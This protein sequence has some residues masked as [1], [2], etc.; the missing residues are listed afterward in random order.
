MTHVVL[1]IRP[2][3]AGE[4]DPAG[5]V[6][7]VLAGHV[8]STEPGPVLHVDV[9]PVGAEESQALAE[10]VLGRQV[11]G[12]VPLQLVLMV[13]SCPSTQQQRHQAK[14][15]SASS[16]LQAASANLNIVMIRPF[17]SDTIVVSSD[18]DPTHS[19]NAA[20]CRAPRERLDS[21][22]HHPIIVTSY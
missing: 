1:D 2:A 22:V 13:H 10:P 16:N 12:R 14:V 4:K 18:S 8:E 6:V 11:E 5:L 21:Q 3:A 15:A 7:A 19:Y 9:G 20:Y 17:Y